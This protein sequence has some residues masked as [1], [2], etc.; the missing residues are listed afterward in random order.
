M[1]LVEGVEEPGGGDVGIDLRGDQTFVAE[2]F[3]YAADVGA[4]VEQVSGKAVSQG[5]RARPP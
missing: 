4:R 5:V 3:L 2:E 1:R